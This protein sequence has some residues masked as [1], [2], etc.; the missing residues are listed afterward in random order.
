MEGETHVYSCRNLTAEV[1]YHAALLSVWWQ[2]LA[3][4]NKATVE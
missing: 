1:I 4:I 2:L 3:W